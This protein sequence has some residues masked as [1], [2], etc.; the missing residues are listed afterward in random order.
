MMSKKM[1]CLLLAC[2]LLLPVLGGHA[3][4]ASPSGSCGAGL[5]W[6]LDY[7]TGVLTISG[8]GPMDDYWAGYDESVYRFVSTAPWWE[9]RDQ[10][11]EIVAEE[12]VTSIGDYAFC[13]DYTDIG[14]NVSFVTLADS[15][16][17]IGESA[18]SGTLLQTVHLG[19]GLKS[20]GAYAFF[21]DGFLRH[22][23]LPEGLTEIGEGAFIWTGITDITIPASV[24]YIG[25]MAVGYSSAMM[26]APAVQTGFVIRGCEGSAAEDCYRQLLS[27]Y[28]ALKAEVG[29]DSWYR[30]RFPADGTVYFVPIPAAAVGVR[31]GGVPVRWT[32]AAPFI[33]AN[34]RT[35]VPL[36]AV[37]E[38][39]GL[40]V[41]WDGAKREAVFT[42]G[43]KTVW[44]PIGSSTART[45]AGTME[46]DTAAVIVGERTYAPVRYLAEYFGF[47]VD[48]DGASR[49]VLIGPGRGLDSA[50][51]KWTRMNHSYW[52]DTGDYGDERLGGVFVNHFYD[53]AAITD[54][55][56]LRETV[57]AALRSGYES[58]TADSPLYDGGYDEGDTN[59]NDSRVGELTQNADGILSLKYRHDWWMGGVGDGSVTGVTVS[60]RTGRLLKL[61]DFAAADGWE[62]TAEALEE[63]ALNYYIARGAATSTYQAEDFMEKQLDE[64]NFYIENNEIILCIAKY[65]LAE[66]AAGGAE[67]PTGV[68]VYEI[69]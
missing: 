52:F 24:T 39:L 9:Y 1:L 59:Y 12:G 50:A 58:F 6:S 37:A 25:D 63:M 66:G 69:P 46:M 54:E 30:E 8:R 18:F 35:L 68:Y 13:G 47:T 11:R 3:L 56:P 62:I 49:T 48:W 17:S 36:R 4:A 53:L 40:T 55:V 7:G 42:D 31:V 60:L 51:V 10:I 33:D 67:I 5:R 22:I 20:I 65:E 44:F 45:D 2:A 43:T 57:N 28:E 29:D 16:T 23:A 15:V 14:Y 19:A 21:A 27:A 26:G 38:A 61:S 32:D 64:L 41:S 34:S